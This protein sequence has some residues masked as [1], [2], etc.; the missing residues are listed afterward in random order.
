MSLEMRKVKHRQEIFKIR[1]TIFSWSQ[2][3]TDR[4]MLFYTGLPSKSAFNT[5]FSLI[6]PSLPNMSYW[7]GTKRYLASR[8]KFKRKYVK[9]SKKIDHLKMSFFDP[10]ETTARA[11]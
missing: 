5:V 9:S 2:I 10:N 4:K 6:E 11:A 8:S 7:R 1:N 3:K